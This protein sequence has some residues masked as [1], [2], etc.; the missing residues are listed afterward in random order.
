[1][2]AKHARE[3]Q[4]HLVVFHEVGEDRFP[5]PRA[6]QAGVLH[7]LERGV[8]RMPVRAVVGMLVFMR[9]RALFGH[10]PV[11]A[12]GGAEFNIPLSFRSFPSGGWTGGTAF[13]KALFMKRR[14]FLEFMGRASLLAGLAPSALLA[15]CSRSPLKGGQGA[16]KGLGFTPIRPSTSDELVLAPE[17]RYQVLLRKDDPIGG[18]LR[19]GANNDYNAFFPFD[20]AG[21]PYDG[22]LWTNHESP[23]PFLLTNSSHKEEKDWKT[24]QAI[25]S[26]M[27]SVGG[28]LVRLYR[29]PSGSWK[30]DANDP[31]NRRFDANTRIPFVAPRP[32]HGST[33]ALGTMGNCAGG[34]TPWGTLLTCEENYYQ[35]YGE[36][37]FNPPAGS[38]KPKREPLVRF[39]SDEDLGWST[40]FKRPPLHY[41]WVVE[42]HPF[43]GAA[44]KLTALGRF[45]HEGAT[46]VQAA[47][48]RTVVYMGEDL[49]D[50]F[51]YKFI[52]DRA[53]SLDTGTLYAADLVKG[54]WLPLSVD[55]N[56]AFSARF[57]DQLDLLTQASA[58]AEL[59]GATPLD[60]PEDIERDPVTGHI[61]VALT[62]N[63]PKG[64][65]YG[66]LL[67]LKE[68]PLALEFTHET[69]IAGG[70]ETGIA[71][72]DNL[73]FGPDGSLWISSDM[74][75]SDMR[76]GKYTA[77]GNN[78][79]YCVPMSGPEAG[80]IFQV[81][82][83]PVGA[84]LT[85][86]EFLPDG[87]LIVSV[88][89]PGEVMAREMPATRT[90]RWPD[91]GSA[92]PRSAV[93]SISKR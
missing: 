13:R 5:G 1:M 60:R 8:E 43:T 81:A 71:C 53:G 28:S 46:C 93:V 65:L 45:T 91:G 25:L 9:N 11:L 44:K 70:P 59:A 58:A 92:I 35:Y 19:F 54:R 29:D 24:R 36:W 14:E 48:G 79:L 7:L 78:G 15:S 57:R 23:E 26:E 75:A 33:F 39:K 72:P 22:M 86:M 63:K 84:E 73:A 85:G 61:I 55:A 2:R 37:D 21:N 50:R 80:R 10:G 17:F 47:D 82:S 3:L 51:L 74:S 83:A 40:R 66:S 88:Q 64:R 6:F 90:S 38:T 67:R 4:L 42:I 52:P 41:G 18:K 20:P 12:G 34:R 30:I 56:P 68:E 16:P 62:N 77:F 69:W 32:I 89:H 27:E 76:A 49:V 87:T 31:R